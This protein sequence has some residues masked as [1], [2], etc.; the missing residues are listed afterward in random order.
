VTPRLGFLGVGWIGKH[1]LDAVA[2][3][4]LAEIAAIADPSEAAVMRAAAALPGVV[5]GRSLD[6]L[7][8]ADLDG[9]VIATPSALHA[10]QAIAALE[11]GLAVFCQK[12]LARDGGEARQVVEAARSADRLLGLDLSYRHIAG[13]D[14][15]RQAVRNGELGQ[16][17]AVDLIFHNAYG[18]SSTWCHDPRLSGGG[19][20]IDLGVHLVDLA[21]WVLD[22][23]RVS[24]VQSRLYANGRPMTRRQDRIVEDY[25][26]ARLEL[27]EGAIM[28]LSCA[29]H[30]QAGQDARIKAAFYGTRGGAALENIE[31]SFYNF[32]AALLRGNS[33]EP[34]ATCADGWGGRAAV[35][36]TNALAAGSRFDPGA[37]RYVE[38]ASVLDRIYQS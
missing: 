31:G 11:H 14:E 8:R 12:P 37:E 35:A 10:G 9:V 3:S 13:V 6:D 18:P 21:M 1:R 33:R 20:V 23:P 25:G 38:V 2:S 24:D 16:V 27:E 5:T 7:L 36:W 32:S 26:V 28:T 4:G 17:F 29:W 30:L 22:F 34:I 15:M 19:C